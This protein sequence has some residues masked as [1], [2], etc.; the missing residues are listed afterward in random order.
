MRPIPPRSNL[1][2]GWAAFR[3]Q[4]QRPAPIHPRRHGNWKHGHYA[5]EDRETLRLVLL[6]CRMLRAGLW[7]QPVFGA[8]KPRPPGWAVFHKHT[9][10]PLHTCVS[11]PLRGPPG[12]RAATTCVM[13]PETLA[14]A[15]WGGGIQVRR[16]I[17]FEA[18]L[19]PPVDRTLGWLTEPYQGVN[20]I[21]YRR[22][23]AHHFGVQEASTQP[24]GLFPAGPIHLRLH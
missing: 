22:Y 20:V 1:P 24:G 23:H 16:R 19:P 15:V 18:C 12:W 17:P 6:C 8:H 13:A 5:K 4:R 21:R 11:L 9:L 2:G 10:R 7:N 14:H 3:A